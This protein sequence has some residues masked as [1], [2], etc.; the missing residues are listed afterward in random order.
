M[1]GNV[2]SI[3]FYPNGTVKKIKFFEPAG[4]DNSSYYPIVPKTDFQFVPCGAGNKPASMPSSF[5]GVAL[6]NT[7][8]E[9]QNE[10]EAQ[11]NKP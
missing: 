3:E 10:I 9:T 7:I 2:K 5:G 8:I 11:R 6:L 1:M 4:L